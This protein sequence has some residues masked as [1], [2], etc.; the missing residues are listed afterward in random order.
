MRNICLFIM[1]L[2]IPCSVQAQ[3]NI[4]KPPKG[5]KIIAQGKGYIVTIG[6]D[7]RR[8][9]IDSSYAD[10]GAKM[11]MEDFINLSPDLPP[12]P[13]RKKS[14][15]W[16]PN[17]PRTGPAHWH[18]R[19]RSLLS[20]AYYGPLGPSIIP[21]DTEFIAPSDPTIKTWRDYLLKNPHHK[22]AKRYKNLF[23][24]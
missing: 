12:N 14:R 22:E 24:K 6:P 13:E 1:C 4:L 2:F 19:P 20:P 10:L 3:D 8:V 23:K 15:S 18:Y 11:H 16:K 7:G 17:P 9:F 21:L 5:T